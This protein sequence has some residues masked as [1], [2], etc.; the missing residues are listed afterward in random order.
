MK[1]LLTKSLMALGLITIS[2]GM[3]VE[4]PAAQGNTTVNFDVGATMPSLKDPKNNDTFKAV[5]SDTQVSTSMDIVDPIMG[6]A[7]YDE[8]V[9]IASETVTIRSRSCER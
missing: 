2:L 8:S 9:E 5:I 4:S 1:N 7:H 3:A 6:V